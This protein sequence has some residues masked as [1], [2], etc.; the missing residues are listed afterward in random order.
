M[1]GHFPHCLN[2]LTSLRVLDLSSNNF[3]GN[4]PSFITNLKSLEYLSLFDTNFSGLFSFSSLTNHSKLEVFLLSP[5]TNNLY[6]ET[7]ESSSWHPTFKL[8]ALQLRNCFLNSKRNGTFP[9]NIQCLIQQIVWF[10]S[11]H[12]AVLLQLMSQLSLG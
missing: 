3:V 10:N 1:S 6:V 4:I 5:R 12:N 2:K 8:K 11:N 7:E 9:S